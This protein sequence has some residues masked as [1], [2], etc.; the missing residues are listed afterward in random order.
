M[1]QLLSLFFID[2]CRLWVVY[3]QELKINSGKKQNEKLLGICF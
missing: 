3:V 2:V 1:Q